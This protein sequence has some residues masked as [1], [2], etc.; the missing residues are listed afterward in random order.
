MLLTLFHLISHEELYARPMPATVASAIAALPRDNQAFIR[1][2]DEGFDEYL[3]RPDEPNT[4][5][6]Q[7]LTD[8]FTVLLYKDGRTFMGC[9]TLAERANARP[10]YSV[11]GVNALAALA[12]YLRKGRPLPTSK[13]SLRRRLHRLEENDVLSHNTRECLRMLETAY[14]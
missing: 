8:I 1:M 5:D 13:S 12:N 2:A 14:E 11:Y 9:L 10:A 7:R 3:M 6:Y 4:A